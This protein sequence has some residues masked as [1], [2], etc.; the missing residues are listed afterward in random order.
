M[1]HMT[2]TA[3]VSWV[4]NIGGG[5]GTGNSVSS[6]IVANAS[7]SFPMYIS[8]YYLSPGSY[9]AVFTLTSAEYP[10]QSVGFTLLVN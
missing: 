2:L 1:I 3:N 7:E 8:T 5:A 4:I 10:T 9:P 6:I